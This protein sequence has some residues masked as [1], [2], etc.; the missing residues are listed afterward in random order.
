[1]G[2]LTRVL[3]VENIISSLRGF[4]MASMRHAGTQ[5]HIGSPEIRKHAES[6]KLHRTTTRRDA[7]NKQSGMQIKKG[8]IVDVFNHME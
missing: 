1:M 8:N 5:L 6:E 4:N 2:L 7:D 3:E